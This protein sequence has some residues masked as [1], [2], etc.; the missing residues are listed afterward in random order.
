MAECWSIEDAR[1]LY[2]IHRWGADYF[3]LNEEGDV[4]VNLPGEG[5]PEAVVLK[6]LIENLRDRG[7]SLPLILRFRNLLDSRIEA[8]N[9]SFRRAAEKHG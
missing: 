6:E 2:G 1:D 8:L 9:S 7:R 4:V 5:D 3:D